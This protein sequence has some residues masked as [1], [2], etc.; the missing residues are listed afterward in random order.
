[1]F[2]H[3]LISLFVALSMVLTPIT[4]AQPVQP[5]QNQVV[6]QSVQLGK[7]EPEAGVLFRTHVTV[8]Q[9]TDWAR[10]A[11]MGVVIL[12]QDATG[13]VILADFDQLADLARLGY[14]PT[15]TDEFNSLVAANS[16][17][18]L[19]LAKAVAPVLERSLA[20][21]SQVEQRTLGSVNTEEAET[22]QALT[23]LRAA[24]QTLTPEVKVAL[25]DSF[26]LDDD[27]DG[28]TNTE[29]VWWCTD[30][31]NPN[32]DR[33]AQGYADGEEVTALLDVIQPRTLRWGYGPPFGPPN[34]WP[35][36]NDRDGTHVKV[37]NDGDF[38]T[39]PDYAEAYMVGTRVGG[40]DSES[41]DH[42]KFDD[43]QELFGI[44]YCPGA[45]TNCGYGSYPAI[46]YWNFIKASMPNWVLPPGDSPFVAA[47]P[48]PEVYVEPSS[49]HVERVTTITTSEGEMTQASHSYETS[50]A[51]GESTS[52]ADTVTWNNW[53]EVSEAVERP[54]DPA[55]GVK[56]VEGFWNRVWGGVQIVGGTALAVGTLVACTGA[57]AITI[58]AAAVPC[59]PAIA[60]AAV[61]GGALVGEGWGDLTNPDE[62]KDIIQ[63]TTNNTTNYNDYSYNPD[64]YDFSEENNI[65]LTLN[66][67]LDTQGIVNSLDGVQY[68]INQQGTLLSRG[69]QDISY[70]I[71][72][73]RLTETHTNGQSWGGAQTTTHEVYE[74]HTISEG[75]AFTTGQ[76]WS[77]AWAV[78]SSHAADLTFNYSVQN[79]GTEYA[80][81][82]S[83]LV[84]NIYIGDDKLPSISYPAWEQFPDG[85]L[86]NLFPVGPNT[87]PGV[88]STKTFVS[89]AIS[90]SLEQMKRIDLGERL[91]VKVE[92]YSYGA[93][94]L[95]YTDAISGGV[96]VFIE[97]GVEDGDESVDQYV[98]PTW[99]VESVQDVLARYFPHGE[100]IDGNLNSL[101]TP[102][103]SGVNA[104]AWNE[105][106]LS[107]IAWWNVYLTQADSGNIPLKDLPAQA[108]SGIL[109]RF[110]RDSDRD[111][112]NDRAEFR[113]YCALPATNPDHVHCSDGYL[114][115]EI[116][117]QPDVLAGYVSQRVGAVVTV[118]LA[119]ENTGTFDAYGI[120]AVMYSPDGTTTIG[121]NTVGGNGQVRPGGHV[122]VG[123]LIVG[124]GLGNWGNSRAKPYAGGQYSGAVD[125]TFTFSAQTP[126]VVGTGSTAVS[127]NDAAGNSG[128]LNLGS[129]YHAP[130]P[131]DVAQGL[132]VG[133][134]TG[135]IDAGTSFTVTALTPRDTFTYTVISDPFTPPVIVVSA[136]D[137]QG[138]HRFVTPV[139]LSNLGDSLAPHA[140]EMLKGLAVQIVATGPFNPTGTNT[141]DLV[142][143][144]PHPATIVD[145]HLHLNFVSDGKLVLE[146]SYTQDIPVGPTTVAADWSPT[147]FSADY[148]PNGD[149]LLIAFWTDSEE[150]IIDSG[151]RPLN[152]FA[153]DP[154]SGAASDIV[155]WDFGTVTQG[156][157]PNRE[158][159]VASVGATDLSTYVTGT[160]G[161]SVSQ[162][163]SKPLGLGDVATYELTLDTRI[164][165]T[166]PYAGTVTLRTSDPTH[167]L[168]TV[169]VSGTI[170]PLVGD[171]YARKIM[172]HPLDVEVW[173]PGIHSQGEW[174]TYTHSL[175]P[176]PGSLHPV[177]VYSQGYGKLLGIG[178]YLLH[179]FTCQD[180][181]NRYPSALD[182]IYTF[183]VYGDE[184][185]PFSLYCHHMSTNP[186]GYLSLVN[187]GDL[188]NFSRAVA[189][190]FWQGTDVVTQFSKVRLDPR[191]LEIDIRDLTFSQSTGHITGGWDFA[192]VPLATASNCAGTS[193]PPGSANVDLRGTLFVIDNSVNFY[194]RGYLANGVT[195]ISN[196]RQLVDLTGWGLCGENGPEPFISDGPR[197][198]LKLAYV[199]SVVANQYSI[200][201][202]ESIPFNRSTLQLPESF[203]TYYVFR[204]Q[205]G[206]ELGFVDAGVRLTTI[207]VPVGIWTSA[208]LNALVS[209]VGNGVVTFKVDVGADGSWDWETTQTVTNAVTFFNDQLAA[210]FTPYVSGT[211]EVDVP[212]KVYLSKPGQVL[213]TN[214]VVE[215]NQSVEL[216]PAFTLSGTPTEGTNVALKTT[217]SNSG[218]ADSGPFTVSYYATQGTQQSYIGSIF[219]PSVS[220]N[221]SIPAS[222]T[223]NTLGFTGPVTVTAVVDPFNRTVELDESNNSKS[224][225]ITI[226]TR[227]DLS[228]AEMT[229]SN[230]E[231][232]VGETVTVTV[233]VANSGQTAAAT[234][235]VALYRGNPDGG[236]T[237]IQV[238][239]LASIPATS[240]RTLTFTWTPTTPGPYQLFV[241]SDRDGQVN[242]SDETNN[243]RPQDVHV[244]FAGPLDVDSGGVGDAA[245]SQVRG[246]GYLNGQP[247]TFCGTDSEQSQRND[248][249]G[250][251]RYRF[252]HL[253][254][255]HHYHLDLVLA[256]CDG[257]GRQESITIDGLPVEEGVDLGSGTPQRLSILVDPAF[258]R[259]TSIEVAIQEIIGYD[260]V[261]SQITLYDIDY[262][263]ADSGGANDP[264]YPAGLAPQCGWIDGVPNTPLG[265]PYQ[266]RRIDLADSNTADDPDNELVYR[267]TGLDPS[268]HYRVA[269]V[270]F[271]GAGNTVEQTVY[272]DSDVLVGSVQLTGNQRVDVAGVVPPAAYSSDGAIDVRIVR[273]NAAAGAFVNEIVLEE[274]T[275]VGSLPPTPTDTPTPTNTPTHTPTPSVTPT[276]TPTNTPTRTPINTPTLTPTATNTPTQTPTATPTTTAS[277]TKTPTSTQT[278]TTT[279]TP[280]PTATKTSTPTPSPTPVKGL[281]QPGT[282]GS[283]FASVGVTVFLAFPPGSVNEDVQ[284]TIEQV[285]DPSDGSGFQVMG[286]IFR[287]T[288]RTLSGTPVTNFNPP[289]DFTVGY[290]SLPL[291]ADIRPV[292]T[293][294]N[295]DSGAW[296]EI[297]T[298]HNP[299]NR[300]LKASVDHLTIFAV[301]QRDGYRVY[302]PMLL[303]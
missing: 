228:V 94:E 284:V 275:L 184:S 12:E 201:Q 262:C 287:I 298:T 251:V 126:G 253:L 54:L 168:Y 77:T 40:G 224:A 199:R 210:A 127:W 95:F 145:G 83:G 143:N 173:V 24:V 79:S 96:T 139:Q 135:T 229:L 268:K 202:V 35:N 119:V 218:A 44:T 211:G 51:R 55:V 276:A 103:F 191:T 272:T 136:S 152:S 6:G 288:A 71:S 14:Q 172:D 105:H 37:C 2:A 68:A 13:V 291:G 142:I 149:N 148:N 178:K 278:G 15:G 49:W 11:D 23:S 153:V 281:I 196:Q 219:V 164:L 21:M 147:E 20:M 144:S 260:A 167:P 125:H 234:Q 176:D 267:F 160:S 128:V 163:G 48:V 67:T 47:F 194:V 116:H 75:Q 88:I 259:D 52:I 249:G 121:N 190:Q 255:G 179:P 248:T 138:S 123:S 226:L 131:L 86:E 207:R 73:P 111:G 188:S 187:T 156:E 7:V 70:Q 295:E 174:I 223:W 289:F 198:S 285:A 274:I 78:D 27:G 180:I 220:T 154:K 41:T 296:E 239:T 258:Y 84:F 243:D 241:R 265:L 90:L 108:G 26:S 63:N 256:E 301:M 101:W 166:G 165:P 60:G 254:P 38:D 242:E 43:G 114:R 74:E 115:P 92:S 133:F 3:K 62:S 137:P 246:Y 57:A 141:T 290:D 66:Q 192:S 64:Y 283:V 118:T 117:P 200:A 205:Y 264:A 279:H 209:D 273:T 39:I 303:R 277:A 65:S 42:D 245:Y 87:P 17:D 110:N 183:Y 282:G 252:D 4:P 31:L 175:V 231:L 10:L 25:A 53:E 140:G 122:A 5:V 97:D 244:G 266:S 158:V 193:V 182:G 214:M 177:K 80:R 221:S 227:P 104:H 146:K 189:G 269:L 150:N 32:S 197:S 134:N 102:E 155:A 76:N 236:D 157:V 28:L 222:F 130:L 106:F 293:F 112:Y 263:Y 98:I 159:S 169:Q 170:D 186:A 302:V 286:Q 292:L 162:A 19:W 208:S 300:T 225:T 99:G 22:M 270:F 171:A 50:V 29:E 69:L 100:D 46:E 16:Q 297:P 212:I 271:Q 85:K 56:S 72:R 107:D 33:D 181:H 235:K 230:A 203:G 250:Q 294:W 124:P 161:L 132:Q 93:D 59:V 89:T 240:S 195:T 185:A 18:R 45:P 204:A 216:S 9:N 81:E 232:V 299:V 238:K 206:R 233:K 151:A 36:F 61:V 247:S 261:V 215:R 257:L 34:A 237:A 217:V 30:P 58:G 129:V 91:T 1:M 280:T 213:L 113:Y 109:F 8:E 82:L 120:D